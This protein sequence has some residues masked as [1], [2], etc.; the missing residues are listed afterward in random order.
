MGSP[1]ASSTSCEPTFAFPA[2]EHPSSSRR[3]SRCSRP[4]WPSAGLFVAYAY[5][6]RNKGPHGL[7]H[8]NKA[9]QGRVHVPREQVLPRHPLHRHHRR[10]HQGPPRPGGLLVQPE[11]ARRHHRR[12]RHRC[13]RRCPGSS[14]GTSTSSSST[15]SSTASGLVVGGI[16]PVPPSHADRQGPAVR[17]HPLRRCGRPRRCSRVRRLGAQDQPDERLPEQLGPEPRDVRPA[18]GRARD[19]RRP[20]GAGVPAQGRS[21]SARAWSW[22]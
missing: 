16:R 5:Y 13:R 11:R 20:Q 22:R 18:R 19:A 21:P 7:T 3:G 6:E 12:H 17:R 14:T 10:R 8:R 9:R 4:S 1:P 2:V 15:A